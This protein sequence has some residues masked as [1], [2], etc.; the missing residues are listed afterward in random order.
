M[1]PIY[2]PT[3]TKKVPHL[4][5]GISLKLLAKSMAG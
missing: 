1:V 2:E 3:D 4:T 5:K